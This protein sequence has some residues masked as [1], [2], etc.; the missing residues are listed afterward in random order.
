VRL[1]QVFPAFRVVVR[2]HAYVLGPAGLR[3]LDVSDPRHPLQ[4]GSYDIRYGEDVAVDGRRAYVSDGATLRILDVTDPRH[5][6][7]P[8]SPFAIGSAARVAV[9]G[10]YVYVADRGDAQ[11]QGNLR[12]VDVVDPARPVEVG[13]LPLS[14]PLA[15]AIAGRYV[16]VG[17]AGIVDVIDVSKPTHQRLVSSLRSVAGL[18]FDPVLD[19]D[20]TFVA[21]GF[22]VALRIGDVTD[23]SNPRLIATLGVPT[24]AE[25]VSVATNYA[26]VAARGAGLHVVDLSV[27][28]APREVAH[29]ALPSAGAVAFSGHRLYVADAVLGL[30]IFDVTDRMHPRE[31]GR[32]GIDQPLGLAASGNLPY[33]MDEL[34]VL[35]VIDARDPAHPVEIGF[36][37]LPPGLAG[38]VQIWGSEAFV[39]HQDSGLWILHVPTG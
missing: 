27:P 8:G 6:V 37:R 18:P 7:L 9:A 25:D 13:T 4:V 21:D 32:Y 1:H 12:V 31:I 16:Y 26:Y 39:A 11:R 2:G 14:S 20:Y 23:L 3:I 36:Y 10:H 30:L 29:V 33:I 38:R 28:T 19:G 5:P 15:G 34:G 17:M 22:G 24:N 35:R